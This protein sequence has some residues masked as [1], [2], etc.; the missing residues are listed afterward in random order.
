[1]IATKSL[2][3]SYHVAGPKIA[4][5]VSSGPLCDVPGCGDRVR[6]RGWSSRAELGLQ[7]GL[8][9]DITCRAVARRVQGV[10]TPVIEGLL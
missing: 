10:G 9:E 8:C 6:F 2:P 7:T 3:R 5:D 1:M 4:T